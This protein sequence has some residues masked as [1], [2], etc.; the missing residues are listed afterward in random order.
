MGVNNPPIAL[1]RA[2]T[3]AEK[4]G[5]ASGDNVQQ[6]ITRLKNIVASD[7]LDDQDN[8]ELVMGL[9]EERLWSIVETIANQHVLNFK[10]NQRLS[11]LEK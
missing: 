10:I 9:V 3:G 7:F 4:V 5:T 6:E 2:S 11:E 8:V 1:F